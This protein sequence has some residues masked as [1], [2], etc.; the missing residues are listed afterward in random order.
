MPACIRLPLP[1]NA[2]LR[3]RLYRYD[4][5]FHPAVLKRLNSYGST[6]PTK[7]SSGL[8]TTCVPFYFRAYKYKLIFAPVI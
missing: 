7:N 4:T 3:D 1:R 6:D 8:C 5:D 2:V